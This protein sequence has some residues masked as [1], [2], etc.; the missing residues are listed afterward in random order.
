MPV[1]SSGISQRRPGIAA[2]IVVDQAYVQS[3]LPA[4]LSWLYPYLPFMQGLQIGDVDAFCA[5]DPPTFSVPTGP[6]IFDFITNG[7]FANVTLVNTFIQNIT[8]AYL[9]YS[10]CQ[11]ASVVTPAPPAA[12]S[13]PANLPA[14]NPPIVG[15][16][17]GACLTE[18]FSGSLGA[19]DARM[20]LRTGTVC[21]AGG[22]S[23]TCLSLARP[24]PAGATNLQVHETVS[25]PGHDDANTAHFWLATV[26][27][28]TASTF[29]SQ[30]SLTVN[31]AGVG[32]APNSSNHSA[33]VAVPSTATQYVVVANTG[34]GGF[35]WSASATVDWF[36]GAPGTV[37]GPPPACCTSSDPV[38]QSTLNQILQMVT[39]IQRNS[40]P[41]AYIP[42]ASHSGLS[43]DGTLTIPS[44]IGMLV[45]ITTVPGYSGVELGSPNEIFDI[46]W[47]SWGT[48]DGFGERVL[49]HKNPQLSFAE[50]A[51]QFTRFGY[52][53]NPGVVATI[54]ELYAEP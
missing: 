41:F 12:P 27:F 10:T 23:P 32:E 18:S 44:C 54:Q 17:T 33:V 46:G 4:A 30:V 25:A 35:G 40:V 48:A 50:K 42:G 19:S 31:D 53:L 34:T 29:V 38:T 37:T 22:A 45:T 15:L 11:C 8:R 43:A 9:W 14:V 24:I 49:I 5:V 36:C 2:G 47:F 1:C 13:A 52:S 26:F 28:Y 6:E 39:L 7:N 21:D 51:S 20:D 16:P 3:I